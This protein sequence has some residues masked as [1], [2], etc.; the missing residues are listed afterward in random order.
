MFIFDLIFIIKWYIFGR[1]KIGRKVRK[2]KAIIKFQ[3]YIN[4][5][6]RGALAIDAGANVGEFTKILL[7]KGFEVHSFEPDPIALSEINK[8]KINNNLILYEKAVGITNS[9]KLLFRYRKFDKNNPI[10]S[11]GSSL[12]EY[13]SGPN[14]PS[15]EIN[16]TRN[17][18]RRF[19]NKIEFCGVCDT[20]F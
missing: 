15:V 10:S 3:N 19:F 8:L 18:F 1:L 5:L 6:P 9:K 16:V 12:L 11:Q 13:R 4:Q 14:M 17:M 7:D 2:K 20:L